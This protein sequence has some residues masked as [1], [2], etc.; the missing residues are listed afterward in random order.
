MAKL[1]DDEEKIID[2]SMLFIEGLGD[3]SQLIKLGCLTVAQ[4]ALLFVAYNSADKQGVREAAATYNSLPC[5]ILH[6]ASFK[7]CT[8]KPGCRGR[9]F[10][11]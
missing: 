7:P 4:C 10:C 5:W 2:E 11:E 8:L 3:T 9:N 6:T 1:G